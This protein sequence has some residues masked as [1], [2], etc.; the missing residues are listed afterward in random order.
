MAQNGTDSARGR[1]RVI[2]LMISYSYMITRAWAGFSPRS[3]SAR[4]GA[5]SY[6]CPPRPYKRSTGL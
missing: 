5:L 2:S 1:T 3:P 4:Q 6:F